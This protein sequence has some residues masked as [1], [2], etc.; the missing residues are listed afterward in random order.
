MT[1]PHCGLVLSHDR[2]KKTYIFTLKAA[3]NILLN[4]KLMC[5]IYFL[6]KSEGIE[7]RSRHAC[8]TFKI[9]EEGG[10]GNQ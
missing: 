6:G 2:K 3:H 7:T 5:I 4:S 10:G 1:L 8:L 9:L